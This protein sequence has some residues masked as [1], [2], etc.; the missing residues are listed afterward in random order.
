VE[1]QVVEGLKQ[2][3]AVLKELNN[4]MKIEDVERLMEDT[5]D[6]V[7][8][9]QE[10]SDLLSS[11]ITEEDEEEI[12]LELEKLHEEEAKEKMGDQ[13]GKLPEVPTTELPKI[14][15]KGMR[16]GGFV[17][18]IGTD[19]CWGLSVETGKVPGKASK[20]STRKKEDLVAA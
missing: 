19:I 3:T 4:E 10:V 16:D 6:A 14:E 11:K 5:A 15:D 13:L 17:I 1:K 20:E 7:A 2:G 8:Y 9:Q 18:L 12:E